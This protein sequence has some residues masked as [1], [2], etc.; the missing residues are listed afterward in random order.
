M[1]R[2]VNEDGDIQL[3]GTGNGT[4]GEDYLAGDNS[5]DRQTYKWNGYSGLHSL[6]DVW[7][8]YIQ[9]VWSVY[10]SPRD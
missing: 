7:S 10:T 1:L 3:G 6:E 5:F 8:M 2:E 4:Y 9:M